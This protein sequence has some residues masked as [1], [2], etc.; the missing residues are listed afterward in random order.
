M[1]NLFSNDHA[2]TYFAL[3]NGATDVFISVLLLSGSDL[4]VSDW[5]KELIVW[6]AGTDQSVYGRG[7]VGFDVGEIA[8]EQKAFLGRKIFCYG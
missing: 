8:W 3:S 2:G 4:A 7:C 6:L 5:E 1:A